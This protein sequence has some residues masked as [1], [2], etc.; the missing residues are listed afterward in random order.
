M[1]LHGLCLAIKNDELINALLYDITSLGHTYANNT[2]L[3]SLRT[4]LAHV[5]DIA[6]NDNNIP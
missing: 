5:Y 6:L 1:I 2:H 3:L 4:F